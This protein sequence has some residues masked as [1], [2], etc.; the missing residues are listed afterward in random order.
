MDASDFI[1]PSST[2]RQSYFNR[3]MSFSVINRS[4][5]HFANQIRGFQPIAPPKPIKE[6]ALIL[7]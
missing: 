4:I 3:I 6:N 7:C 1:N 5:G 2:Q